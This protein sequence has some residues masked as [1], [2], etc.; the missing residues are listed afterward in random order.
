M[1]GVHGSHYRKN[2]NELNRKRVE[3]NIASIKEKEL[4]R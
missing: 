2:I 3:S 4:A 1:A